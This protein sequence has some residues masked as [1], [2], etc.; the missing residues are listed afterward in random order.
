VH[1]D[2]VSQMHHL[3]GYRAFGNPHGPFLPFVFM[4]LGRIT[5]Y[6]GNAPPPPKR[7]AS[8]RL[9]GMPHRRSQP[10]IPQTDSLGKFGD[11]N[12]YRTGS[13]FGTDSE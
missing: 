11:M 8:G 7:P 9:A 3:T 13:H 5:Y 4:V 6:K 10:E 12:S 1:P 2:L